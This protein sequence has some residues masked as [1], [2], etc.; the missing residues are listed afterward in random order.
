MEKPNL[1][2]LEKQF[3]KYNEYA[4]IIQSQI[5]EIESDKKERT[6]NN[7]LPELYQDLEVAKNNAHR[8]NLAIELANKHNAASFLLAANPSIMFKVYAKVTSAK[9]ALE[10]KKIRLSGIEKALGEGSAVSWVMA[11]FYNTLTKLQIEPDTDNLEFIATEIYEK[12]KELSTPEVVLVFRKIATG[13]FGELYNKANS[14]NILPCFAAYRIERSKAILEIEKESKENR[15]MAGNML[16]IGQAMQAAPEGSYLR[17]L[18]QKSKDR[19]LFPRRSEK[20]NQESPEIAKLKNQQF[21]LLKKMKT[22][23]KDEVERFDSEYLELSGK[24]DNLRRIEAI[25]L[26][27]ERDGFSEVERDRLEVELSELMDKLI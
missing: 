3:N 8:N 17:E 20:L 4:R 21:D 27:L 5:D 26:E 19:H 9:K 23:Y 6:F 1:P 25:R 14:L 10:L 11:M 12:N 16:K 15:S 24:I 18:S 2:A 7:K 22:A 13:G